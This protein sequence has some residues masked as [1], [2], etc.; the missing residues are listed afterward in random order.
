MPKLSSIIEQVSGA[1]KMVKGKDVDFGDVNGTL[2]DSQL[3]LNDK[4]LIDDV[5]VD[6]SSTQNASIFTT[7]VGNLK[8]FISTNISTSGNAA[9]AT[10]VYV[11][12]NEGTGENNLIAFIA[13]AATT[14]GNHSL[15]MDGDF[16]YNPGTG[17]V[18][19]TGFVGDLTGNADT[20]TTNANLTGH[21]TSSGNTTSLNSFTLAQ[22]N[23]AIS[24]GSVGD[25]NVI[26]GV[27]NG[28]NNR[29]ATFTSASALN[30]EQDFTWDGTELLLSSSTASK[31]RL[32]IRNI[33]NDTND[34]CEINLTKMRADDGV[35]QGQNLGEIWF[36]GQNSNQI[37]DTSYAFIIG[38]I[39]VGTNNEESGSLALGVATHDGDTRTGLRL[40]GGSVDD[41]IDVSIGLGAHS[42]TTIKGD[43]VVEGDS[44]TLNT[45]TVLP[46]KDE[47]DMS[48]NSATHVPT[49]QSVKAY[50]DANAGGGAIDDL[51]DVDT[52]GDEAPSV[53]DVLKWNGSNWV[54]AVYNATFTFSVAYNRLDTPDTGT[55]SSTL[56][57]MGSGQ[58]QSSIVHDIG[59]T[60]GPSGAFASAPTVARSGHT[61][62]SGVTGGY[63]LTTTSN[64]TVATST[65]LNYP[66]TLAGTYYAYYRFIVTATHGGVTDSNGP[67]YNIY[68]RN[69]KFFGPQAASSLTS[70]QVIGLS[71]SDWMKSSSSNTSTDVYTQ[72]EVSITC[73]NQYVYYCYPS[74][75][76]G[77]PTFKING[78]TTPFTDIASSSPLSVTN[79]SGFT[80]TYKV[81]QSENSYG[82]SG[83]AT[84]TFQVI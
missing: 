76:S 9:T 26:T 41:E 16:H 74:R 37:G 22:L 69:K 1:F 50:V 13:D 83:A 36:R 64:G 29:V 43:V 32:T 18:T 20:V 62:S 78:F 82:A 33:S 71:N 63:P 58:Y 68:F 10:K 55:A 49:Q 48:S 51:S 47:D 14:D 44:L 45:E 39:D 30:G 24:D 11:T 75:I 60:N 12:D 79:A 38:E 23:S 15:E 80:E 7:T 61:P 72:A 59:Y 31:P 70:A 4:I 17:K 53:N 27:S 67:A 54:P 25:V 35:E 65:A 3:H 56:V 5:S 34:G 2:N 6:T 46:M 28:A 19:A 84:L 73:N 81:W 8:D 40:T 66:S 42:V 52:S 57:L 77:T 21:I